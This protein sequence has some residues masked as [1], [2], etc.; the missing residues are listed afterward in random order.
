MAR[1]F[2]VTNKITLPEYTN[3]II[4]KELPDIGLKLKSSCFSGNPGFVGIWQP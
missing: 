1:I 4:E 3:H 2:G